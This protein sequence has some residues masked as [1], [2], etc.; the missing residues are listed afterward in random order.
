[1]QTR[2]STEVAEA[3]VEQ[4][5]PQATIVSISRALIAV[6]EHADI[7]ALAI[8]TPASRA[9]LN[10]TFFLS[11]FGPLATES[12]GKVPCRALSSDEKFPDVPPSP[13]SIVSDAGQESRGA[14]LR[15]WSHAR[16]RECRRCWPLQLPASILRGDV[17]VRQAAGSPT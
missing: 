9:C 3:S 13:C 14:F 11:M 5:I 16:T 6:G 17:A 10:T 8:V 2:A 4:G 15:C 1:V 7:A 12:V